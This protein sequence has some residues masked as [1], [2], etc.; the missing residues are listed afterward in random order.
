MTSW[1]KIIVGLL[2]WVC[3]WQTL[4][5]RLT[6]HSVTAVMFGSHGLWLDLLQQ[7]APL[8]LLIIIL[9]YH[10]NYSWLCHALVGAVVIHLSAFL[11]VLPG[12]PIPSSLSIVL[13]SCSLSDL[14][15]PAHGLY[16]GIGL[17]VTQALSLCGQ[18]I[19]SYYLQSQ[20]G[21]KT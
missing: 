5:G 14:Y 12:P 1:F 9:Y 10:N 3:C 13:Y 8:L 18:Y 20:T 21:I 15:C 7:S 6:Y 17:T 11:P 19:S 4:T 16:A 2:L